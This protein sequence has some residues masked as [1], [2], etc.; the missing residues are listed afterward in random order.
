MSIEIERKFLVG[1][2]PAAIAKYAGKAIRQ[3]YL[4]ITDDGT[5][6]RIRQKGNRFF[7][8]IKRGEGL[9]RTEIEIE[10]TKAQFEALWPHT[11][12]RRVSKTRYALPLGA[13]TAEVDV[14]NGDLQ[15][16][17]LVEV[18]FASE[19]ASREFSPPDWFGT[20]V[21]DDKRYTNKHLAAYGRPPRPPA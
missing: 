17:V 9:C 4:I 8:T 18:E 11:Q 20:E 21:T 14:F 16:L 15:G 10:I 7:Q 13:Y 12:N 6:L 19:S 3:G 5:E 1:E 2:L